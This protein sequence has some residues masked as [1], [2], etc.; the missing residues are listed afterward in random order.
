MNS[1]KNPPWETFVGPTCRGSYALGTA[2]G[3]CDK[4]KWEREQLKIRDDDVVY[5]IWSVEDSK[6]IHKGAEKFRTCLTTTKRFRTESVNNKIWRESL[7]KDTPKD[8][9]YE[10]HIIE[11]NVREKYKEPMKRR[12]GN[13]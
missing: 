1:L 3:I 13:V 8:N 4:C 9:L 10:I 5:G 12:K 7:P 6:Y 11:I 2:C